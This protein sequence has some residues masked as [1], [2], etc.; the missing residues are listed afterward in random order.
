M[1]L[2]SWR[3]ASGGVAVAARPCPPALPVYSAPSCADRTSAT[4]GAVPAHEL[5][6]RPPEIRRI[7]PLCGSRNPATRF[8]P[9]DKREPPGGMLSP[10]QRWSGIPAAPL[11]AIGPLPQAKR[12]GSRGRPCARL[13]G[14][15]G[16]TA[17]PRRCRRRPPPPLPAPP[18]RGRLPATERRFQ[19]PCRRWD[20]R[21]GSPFPPA[22]KVPR[23]ADQ[24][25]AGPPNFSGAFR[26]KGDHGVSVFGRTA[27]VAAPAI[28]GGGVGHRRPNQRIARRS[29]PR[30]ADFRPP[31]PNPAAPF[32][33]RTL[34][35]PSETSG[36]TGAPGRSIRPGRRSY[37][38]SWRARREIH[39]R[40]G[41]GSAARCAGRPVSQ[42]RRT[43][44]QPHPERPRENRCRIAAPYPFRRTGP[45]G[46][47]RPPRLRGACSERRWPSGSSPAAGRP[48]CKGRVV[49]RR[50]QRPLRRRPHPRPPPHQPALCGCISR[51]LRIDA[52]LFGDPAADFRPTSAAGAAS[53]PIFPGL[54]V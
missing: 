25:R 13:P 30:P 27:T 6:N 44:W 9:S 14:G 46:T 21:H 35:R 22:D 50:P 45:S 11:Q 31:A 43:G 29:R 10:F 47:R 16:F 19:E 4:G 24:N 53:A 1:P 36:M 37:P 2:K 18:R 51:I 38:A 15:G 26:P 40:S 48:F 5:P 7:R 49:S 39:R 23:T 41:G 54:P 20:R 28:L 42:G 12:H 33:A 17:A 52:R 3:G 8:S 34:P 32:G